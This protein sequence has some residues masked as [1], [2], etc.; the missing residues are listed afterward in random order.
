MQFCIL[1]YIYY[2]L[3][4]IHCLSTQFSIVDKFDFHCIPSAYFFSQI[5]HFLILKKKAYSL[6][7]HPLFEIFTNQIVQ[8]LWGKICLKSNVKC[9]CLI[10]QIIHQ[11]NLFQYHQI[12]D[13][14]YSHQQAHIFSLFIHFS[15]PS[16]CIQ[17]K[18]IE[19]INYV[20]IFFLDYS[21]CLNCLS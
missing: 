18:K 3:E 8:S 6:R 4:A 10:F 16:S 2:W 15:F 21:N 13:W 1:F 12:W 9:F 17:Y 5:P 14:A 7:R 19:V 11:F 20:L